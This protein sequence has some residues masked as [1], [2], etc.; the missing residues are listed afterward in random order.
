MYL[1]FYIFRYIYSSICGILFPYMPF[2]TLYAKLVLCP[3][4]LLTEIYTSL[5]LCPGLLLTEI[6]TSPLSR[7]I[8]DGKIY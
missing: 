4:L 3:G 8:T 5:V 2:V 6:Y 1:Y 7:F